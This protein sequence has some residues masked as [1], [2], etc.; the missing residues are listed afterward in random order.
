MKMPFNCMLLHLVC[1]VGVGVDGCVGFVTGV[2]G[3]G[4]VFV[5]TVVV[6]FVVGCGGGCGCVT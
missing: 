3:V 4:F 5:L 2:A 6:V 1:G